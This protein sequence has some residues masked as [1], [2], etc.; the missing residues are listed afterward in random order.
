V[1][2]DLPDAL[3]PLDVDEGQVRQALLNLCRNALEAMTGGGTLTVRAAATDGRLE[4]LVTDT[5]AGIAPEHLPRVFEPFF[6]TKEH[7]TG[8]GL[9]LT[10]HIVAA[11]G[12]AIG[13]ESTPG[14]GTEFRVRLPLA[15]TASAPAAGADAEA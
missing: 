14:R 2:A 12:G 13:I 1:V 8:L 3:P 11:H 7:G 10:Q 9:A 4:I 5:G 6:S 15:G